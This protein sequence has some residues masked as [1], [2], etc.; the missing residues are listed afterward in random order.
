[1]RRFAPALPWLLVAVFAFVFVFA[2]VLAGSL[3]AQDS[4]AVVHDRTG[5]FGPILD[6]FW[7]VIV[8][9][10]TSLAVKL[11]AKANAGFART[12]E[13]VKWAA[14][15]AFAL[16]FNV[17]AH[18]AGVGTVNTLAPDFSLAFVQMGAAA[19]VYKFGQHRVPNVPMS[20]TRH[21]I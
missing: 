15:Y 17:F 6:R 11:I 7:P 4:T 8:T 19:L 5:L 18:W 10:L 16:L 20:T 12:S 3:F 21:P 9:V 14:L 13:P 2:S 1:M